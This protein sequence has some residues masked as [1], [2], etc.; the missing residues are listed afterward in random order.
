MLECTVYN[1]VNQ[2]VALTLGSNTALKSA[3][4]T[5]IAGNTFEFYGNPDAT[6]IAVQVNGCEHLRMVN[7]RLESWGQGIVITPGVGGSDTA[8]KLYFGNVSCFPAG[9]TDGSA[10]AAVVIQTSGKDAFEIR[11]DSC[12]LSPPESSTA[13]TGGG[14]VIEPG[15]GDV[16]DQI[17]FV[18]C[19]ACQWPGPGLNI[20]GGTNIEVLGGYYSCNGAPASPPT[21][22][23]SAG[24]AITGPAS[25][26]RIVGAAC[27]DSVF[28]AVESGGYSFVDESQQYGIYVGGASDS[29]ATN[30]RIHSCDLTGNTESGV[31]VTGANGAPENV[32]IKHCDLSGVP[33]PAHVVTPVTNVQI[34]ECPGYNDQGVVV[35]TASPVLGAHFNGASNGHYGPVTF[36]RK[37]RD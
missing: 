21:T 25:G 19:H 2:G 13:Y 15:E 1:A 14:I 26:V 17:C 8:R 10:G 37:G 23:P 32:F 3:I 27:N 29:G 16:V 6:S 20:V 33:T 24:I 22:L 30:V 9:T 7:N 4:E 35:T 12:E 36:T 34:T 5:Y 31:Y 11:F 18:D 28:A